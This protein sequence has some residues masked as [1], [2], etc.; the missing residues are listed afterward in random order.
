[1]DPKHSRPF[2][3]RGAALSEL[4]RCRG[5]AGRSVSW[6]RMGV[7]RCKRAETASGDTR[8]RVGVRLRDRSE[9]C[10]LTARAGIRHGGGANAIRALAGN[11]GTC[12]ADRKCGKRRT[13]KWQSTEAASRGG[14]VRSREEGVTRLKPR[15]HLDRRGSMDQPH[16]RTTMRAE[17]LP[18]A[19]VLRVV[20]ATSSRI[21]ALGIEGLVK[22]S[23]VRR[24]C[25]VRFWQRARVRFPGVTR[26]KF[27]SSALAV[28]HRIL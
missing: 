25:D 21:G 24:N 27:R 4:G 26:S 16:G 15:C 19:N 17:S 14:A 10:L 23:S 22:E 20:R 8:A 12:Y 9:R 3:P 7:K 2:C 28:R 6:S 11:V 1:M 18:T 5:H 13:R